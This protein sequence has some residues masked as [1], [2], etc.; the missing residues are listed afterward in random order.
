MDPRP[1]EIYFT[2]QV[3]R[4]LLSMKFKTLRTIIGRH[5]FPLGQTRPLLI[6]KSRYKTPPANCLIPAICNAGICFTPS[7]DAIQVVP[8]KNETSPRAT[9]ALERVPRFL[10]NEGYRRFIDGIYRCTM[11]DVRC[12]ILLPAVIILYADFVLMTEMSDTS[13]H[14]CQ[15][16]LLT[17]FNR[18]IV[19][20]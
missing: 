16:V 12:T 8:Q 17:I 7:F 13:H 18:I 11:Y 14:H 5:S 3:D 19:T 2:P 9:N 1:A 6:K 20:N 15:V 4:A 10:I